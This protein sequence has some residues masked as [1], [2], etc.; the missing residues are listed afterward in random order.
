MAGIIAGK[1]V[2]LICL[3]AYPRIDI[4]PH[5]WI[6]YGQH[7]KTAGDSWNYDIRLL[8]STD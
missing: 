4:F 5:G 1:I 3:R 2:A 7:P 8:F 6:Q